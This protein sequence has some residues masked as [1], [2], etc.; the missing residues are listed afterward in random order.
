MNDLPLEILDLILFDSTSEDPVWQWTTLR[1]VSQRQKQRVDYHFRKFWLPWLM[2]TVKFDN[3]RAGAF[4]QFPSYEF[5]FDR[6]IE[7]AD[8]VE[9]GAEIVQYKL[10]IAKHDPRSS[11]L[12]S[13]SW[14]IDNSLLAELPLVWSEYIDDL[15]ETGHD[16]R[17]AVLR[18]G[19]GCPI[20]NKGYFG[21]HFVNDTDICGIKVAHDG[22]SLTFDWHATINQLM[23]EEAKMQKVRTELRELAIERL[24]VNRTWADGSDIST[25]FEQERALAP[26]Y[27]TCIVRWGR[28][29]VRRYRWHRQGDLSAESHDSY[30]KNVWNRWMYPAMTHHLEDGTFQR[31]WAQEDLSRMIG[32]LGEWNL[33]DSLQPPDPV[34]THIQETDSNLISDESTQFNAPDVELPSVNLEGGENANN[35]DVASTPSSHTESLSVESY[36]SGPDNG[37]PFVSLLEIAEEELS[38]VFQHSPGWQDFSEQQ[39]YEL[40]QEVIGWIGTQPGW[41]G[42]WD[43]EIFRDEADK[44]KASTFMFGL[45]CP[46]VKEF[47]RSDTAWLQS[48]RGNRS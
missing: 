34:D 14:I 44:R 7:F 36:F 31:S 20:L 23:R 19:V 26:A 6:L 25:R 42:Y 41:I 32:E 33:E 10:D 48:R 15:E 16:G 22:L 9:Q 11:N 13:P 37:Y 27:A 18:L 24:K 1:H 3:P 47:L 29:C 30:F 2:I 45:E 21:S 39:L 35:E 40:H 28:Q 4:V 38:P 12:D 8:D 43:Y 5:E 17:I 46:D